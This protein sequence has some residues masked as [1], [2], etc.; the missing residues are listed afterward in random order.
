VDLYLRLLALP[1]ASNTLR[2]GAK[3]AKGAPGGAYFFAASA[4]LLVLKTG[5]LLLPFASSSRQLLS[6][7]VRDSFSTCSVS[8]RAAKKKKEQRER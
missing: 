2:D 6:I 1:Y 3:G 7:A 4:L 5:Y 8:Q